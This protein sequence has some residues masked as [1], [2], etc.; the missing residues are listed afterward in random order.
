[1]AIEAL[2]FSAAHDGGAEWWRGGRF[3]VNCGAPVT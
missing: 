2:L 3:L 1:L